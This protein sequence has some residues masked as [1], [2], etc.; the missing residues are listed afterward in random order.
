MAGRTA[1]DAMIARF[2]RLAPQEPL[3]QAALLLLRTPQQEFPVI[4]AWGRP[5]GALGRGALVAGLARLGGTAPVL[6]AMDRRVLVVAPGAPL[7]EVVGALRAG[8]P[9]PAVVV[10]EAGIE[11]IVTLD[12]SERMMTLLGAM[13]RSPRT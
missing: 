13:E 10:G 7:N 5:V 6:E 2:E 11:G 9:A 12:S 3:E 8:M 1:A 4:D